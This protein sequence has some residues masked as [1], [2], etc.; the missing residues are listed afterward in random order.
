M[1]NCMTRQSYLIFY[2]IASGFVLSST[3]FSVLSITPVPRDVFPADIR[4]EQVDPRRSALDIEG[5]NEKC[6]TALWVRRDLRVLQMLCPFAQEFERAIHIL[7]L[8]I[9]PF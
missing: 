1:N 8:H 4:W 3:T 2:P 7:Q 5:G 6:R 9:L